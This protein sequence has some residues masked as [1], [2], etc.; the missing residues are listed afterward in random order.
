MRPACA[1]TNELDKSQDVGVEWRAVR[2]MGTHNSLCHSTGQSVGRIFPRM[3][4]M[5]VGV[6]VVNLVNVVAWNREA[7]PFTPK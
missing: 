4:P 6:N 2:Y 3:C 1:P 5:N 7:A